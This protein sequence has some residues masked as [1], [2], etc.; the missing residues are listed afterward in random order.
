M[1][2]IILESHQFIIRHN[3]YSGSKYPEKYAESFSG[4]PQELI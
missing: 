1:K 2:L 3:Y 4:D